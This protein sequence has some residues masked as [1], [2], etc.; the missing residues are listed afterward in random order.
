MNEKNLQNWKKNQVKFVTYLSTTTCK[1]V[2]STVSESI[3]SLNLDIRCMSVVTLRQREPCNTFYD[4]VFQVLKSQ[5]N[6]GRTALNLHR[7]RSSVISM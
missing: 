5:L 6:G 4:K 3:R 1:R 2:G 7:F